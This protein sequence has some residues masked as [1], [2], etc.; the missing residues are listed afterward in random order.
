MIISISRC[1]L[2]FIYN[3]KH[4]AD[5]TNDEVYVINFTGP[6]DI[7]VDGRIANT[8]EVLDIDGQHYSSQ[9]EVDAAFLAAGETI[10]GRGGIRVAA[11]NKLLWRVRATTATTR[12]IQRSYQDL[13]NMGILR[14]NNKSG[15]TGDN[16]NTFFTTTN[17]PGDKD[18]KLTSLLPAPPA[19]L[20]WKGDFNNDGKVDGAD[21]VIWRK[22]LGSTTNLQA[23]ANGSLN[24]DAADYIHW[25]N[26]FGAPPGSGSGLVRRHSRTRYDDVNACWLRQ[27]LGV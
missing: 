7:T 24:I 22:T 23:D 3:F 25:R 9:A 8:A 11:A 21:Y 10:T 17:N 2:C 27:P 20:K 18:Y 6:G 14:A 5:P 26:N 1:D 12:N 16:F 15:L 13:W 4:D 19:S